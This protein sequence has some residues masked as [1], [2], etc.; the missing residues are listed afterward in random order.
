MWTF[1]AR[2]PDPDTG[3]SYIKEILFT[4]IMFKVIEVNKKVST[5]SNKI[6]AYFE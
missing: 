4:R 3:W 5:K 2:L 6:S 1:I